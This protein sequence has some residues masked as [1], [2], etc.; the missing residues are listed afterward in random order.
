MTDTYDQTLV[1]GHDM[2]G[3]E[4]VAD[5]NVLAGRPKELLI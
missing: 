1:S 4:D 3:H 2:K 5:A